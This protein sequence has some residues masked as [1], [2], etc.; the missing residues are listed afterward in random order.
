MVSRR[1]DGCG[2]M[3]VVQGFGGSAARSLSTI[4]ANG[5]ATAAVRRVARPQ[6]ESGDWRST[7]RRSLFLGGSQRDAARHLRRARWRRQRASGLIGA[8]GRRRREQTT[9]ASG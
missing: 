8:R 1:T 6:R 5:G 9:T 7:R 2:A 3:L 4:I